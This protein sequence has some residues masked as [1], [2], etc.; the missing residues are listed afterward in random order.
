MISKIILILSLIINSVLIMFVTGPLPFL[1]F[2]SVLINAGLFWV[3]LRLFARLE[4]SN[5]DV[6][7]LLEAVGNLGNHISSV[8]EMEM[9]YGEPIIQGMM[10]HIEEVTQE[11]EEYKFKY[12]NEYVEEEYEE[13]PE[14]AGREEEKEA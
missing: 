8:H 10:E 4:E 12:S 14:N 7:S 2:L 3:S 5:E 1:L 9:F 13:T 6:Q 11:I